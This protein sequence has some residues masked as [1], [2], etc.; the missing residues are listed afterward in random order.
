MFGIFKRWH[1]R[2]VQERPF[3]DEWRAIVEENVALSE[4]LTP[5]EREELEKLI[6][7]F[8]DEKR[9]EGA[10]GLAITDEIRVTI[11]AQACILLLHRDTDI[12]PT[13]ESIV[14]YPTAYRTMTAESLG[15]GIVI[16][17]DQIRLGESWHQGLVVLAWDAVRSGAMNGTDGRNVVLH[18]FAHQLDQEDGEADGAPELADRASRKSWAEVLGAEYADLREHVHVGEPSDIDDYGATSPAE[19]FAVVTEMFFEQSHRLKA[20][21]PALYERFASFYRQDPAARPRPR[22]LSRRERRRT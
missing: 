21:H 16:E 9:F 10:G 3:P 14:V 18:E 19:F 17:S 6:L 12:Y 15:S 13:L 20:S 8:L 1:R 7:V 22:R 5:H 11:A 4:T 2:H